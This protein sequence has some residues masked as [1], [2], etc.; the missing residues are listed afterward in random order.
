MGFITFIEVE[1]MSTIA[2]RIEEI[3][4]KYIIKRFLHCVLNAVTFKGRW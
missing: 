2:E 4:C 1:F 3:G